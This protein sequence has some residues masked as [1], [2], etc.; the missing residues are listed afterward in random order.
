MYTLVPGEW[1][2]FEMTALLVKNINIIIF[3]F[4]VFKI[5]QNAIMAVTMF[6]QN[7]FKT[8]LFKHGIIENIFINVFFFSQECSQECDNRISHNTANW[9]MSSFQTDQYALVCVQFISGITIS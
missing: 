9:H 7:I 5:K 8:G 1:M 4:T 2:S 3:N 6:A